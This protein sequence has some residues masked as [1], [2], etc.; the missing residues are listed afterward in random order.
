MKTQRELLAR[1]LSLFDNI[2]QLTSYMTITEF[3][4]YDLYKFYPDIDNDR[5]Y[6]YRVKKKNKLV[7][8]AKY[9][10]KGLECDGFEM[11][12][13]VYQVVALVNSV[14]DVVLNSV[15]M[16]QLSGFD[17]DVKFTLSKQECQV[18]HIKYEPGLQ[19]FPAGLRWKKYTSRIET[20]KTEFNE[21]DMSTYPVSRIDGNIRHIIL[22]LDRF[23]ADGNYVYDNERDKK[24]LVDVFVS[25]MKVTSKNLLVSHKD[26]LAA[27]VPLF[28]RDESL[29]FR[30]I[31]GEQIG[32]NDTLYLEVY[33]KKPAKGITTEDGIVGIPP[34]ALSGKR[35][36]DLFTVYVDEFKLNKKNRSVIEM[37]QSKT[38]ENI[39]IPQSS[40]IV[41]IPN[42]KGIKADSSISHRRQ[43]VGDILFDQSK[44][45]I[46]LHASDG[47]WKYAISRT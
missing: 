40:V 17:S 1:E 12:S 19:L 32:D 11:P 28:K 43:H 26:A 5:Y 24:W 46:I 37:Y 21:A 30:V 18:L 31:S 7:R 44:D 8:G 6:N 38:S 3:Q 9:I 10:L 47:D 23:H 2:K 16:R 42:L 45:C 13:R 35:V 20:G 14:N 15:V 25:S 22:K 27:G 4:A 29:P 41:S 34:N 33:L 39:E 36:T